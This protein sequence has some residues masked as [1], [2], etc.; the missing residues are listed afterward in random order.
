MHKNRTID[1]ASTAC[2]EWRV[3][4]WQAVPVGTGCTHHMRHIHID[5]APPKKGLLKLFSCYLSS[6]RTFE[7]NSLETLQT[8]LR[9]AASF[10][11]AHMHIYVIC[12]EFSVTSFLTHKVFCNYQ[13]DR[14]T[15]ALKSHLHLNNTA[16]RFRTESSS[17]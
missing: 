3:P 17:H 11:S 5:C 12:T 13:T 8:S 1:T 4:V 6:S 16:V 10:H 14:K 9:Y 15:H 7:P 2:R